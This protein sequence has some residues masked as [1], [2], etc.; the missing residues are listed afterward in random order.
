MTKV[1]TQF[2]MIGSAE[3]TR[4]LKLLGLGADPAVSFALRNFAENIMASSK[5]EVP[6]DEGVLRASGHVEP[7]RRTGS[8]VTVLLGYGGPAAP[9]ALEQHE[10]LRF[11]HK[12]G[13]AKYLENPFNA[14]A[15]LAEERIAADLQRKLLRN[16][17][18]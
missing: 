16:V 13:K 15:P 5:L 8:T 17:F 3:I 9:Y 18:R 10:N 1:N 6:V 11:R 4:N 14:W 12:V 2:R 7:P